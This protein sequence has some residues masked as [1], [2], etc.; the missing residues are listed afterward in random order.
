M[1][2][3]FKLGPGCEV[4][5]LMIK[6]QWEMFVVQN[7]VRIAHRGYPNTPQAGKWVTM[8]PGWIVTEE[9]TEDGHAITVGYNPMVKH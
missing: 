5:S 1:V 9:M 8:E 3:R 6:G 2:K 4:H 7:G